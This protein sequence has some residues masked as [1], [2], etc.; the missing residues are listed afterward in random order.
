[1]VRF[2]P[3]SGLQ[4]PGGDRTSEER[5]A[6]NSEQ[7][8]R[9]R[10]NKEKGEGVTVWK[11]DKLLKNKRKLCIFPRTRPSHTVSSLT[12]PVLQSFL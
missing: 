1:M 2:L 8:C 7:Q 10:A 4:F 3:K 6:V 12:T 9:T 5:S 11:Q